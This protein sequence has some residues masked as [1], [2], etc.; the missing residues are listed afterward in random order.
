MCLFEHL[1]IFLNMNKYVLGCINWTECAY[2]CPFVLE[3]TET[4]VSWRCFD[5]INQIQDRFLFVY[6]ESIGEV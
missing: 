5:G 3:S 1:F 2:N 6:A 4:P